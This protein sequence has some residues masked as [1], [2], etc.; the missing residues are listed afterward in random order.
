MERLLS[1][2]RCPLSG[3]NNQ[4]TEKLNTISVPCPWL[5]CYSFQWLYNCST[6]N[7]N[8]L[9]VDQYMLLL[10]NEVLYLSFTLFIKVIRYFLVTISNI[11]IIFSRCQF[12]TLMCFG[13]SSGLPIPTLETTVLNYMPVYFC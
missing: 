9:Y 5:N 3:I 6:I 4:T 10:S 12:P 8:W 1:V 7:I 2:L 11:Y 13:T